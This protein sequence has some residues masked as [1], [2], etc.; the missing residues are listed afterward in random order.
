MTKLNAATR[1]LIARVTWLVVLGVVLSI[2]AYSLYYVARHLGVPKPF[3][4]GMSTAFDG[5]ALLMANYAV[6]YAQ[7][8]RSGTVPRVALLFATGLSAWLNSLHSILGHE[9][10]LAIPLWAALPILSAVLFEVHTGLVRSKALARQGYKYPSPNPKYGGWT[11]ALFP[12]KTLDS[13]RDIVMA[14]LNALNRA[15]MPAIRPANVPN[16][17]PA[18]RPEP[19]PANVANGPANETPANA[20]VANEEPADE[21]ADEAASGGEV[22]NMDRPHPKVVRAWAKQQPQ[23]S[24]LGDRARIPQAIWD[25]YAAAHQPE[26]RSG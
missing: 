12:L 8:G 24:D 23:Y 16:R 21:T 10:P 19:N 6:Q 7:D 11:W 5:T 26:E 14:R 20:N 18:N 4:M 1:T 22:I 15:N 9:S 2:S 3:A 25:A 13:L 17:T